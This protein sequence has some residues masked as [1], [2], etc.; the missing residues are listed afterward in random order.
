MASRPACR[1]PG[2]ISSPSGLWALLREKGCASSPR[3][4]PSRFNIDAHLHENLQ[5]PGSFNVPGGYFLSG[6]PDDLDPS[7]FGL[8]PV[9]AR[10]LDPQQR[11]LLEVA[12]E[13]LESAGVTLDSAA[14]TRTGVF[15]GCFTA[16]Y[17]Q[18]L[19][20]EPDFRHS[21]AATGCDPGIIGARI[22][23]VFDLRG[24]R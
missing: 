11:R 22:G 19:T 10:W 24:P 15:V 18:M 6:E 12:Y 14:G 9:E 13:S 3:V 4:P 8:S 23:H 7:F 5:R 1:L 20:K 21:Y 17:Q 16:D 2:D